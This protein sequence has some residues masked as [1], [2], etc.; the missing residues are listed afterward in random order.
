MIYSKSKNYKSQFCLFQNKPAEQNFLGIPSQY[1]YITPPLYQ[2]TQ[3]QHLPYQYTYYSPLMNMLQPVTNG[4][5]LPSYPASQGL[6]DSLTSA[7]NPQCS[8]ENN[9][10]TEQRSA[11]SATDKAVNINDETEKSDDATT[12]NIP[13]EE[14][15]TEK[16]R[17]D[18]S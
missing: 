16:N 8:Y 11:V 18:K 4:Y 9:A 2:P 6:S 5:F 14:K 3:Y 7:F 12:N 1:P 10:N 17:T 13:E 15:E